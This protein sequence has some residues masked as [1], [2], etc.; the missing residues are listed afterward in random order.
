MN[1]V[2]Q[3]VVIGEPRRDIRG[4][5]LVPVVEMWLESK[6]LNALKFPGNYGLELFQVEFSRGEEMSGDASNHKAIESIIFCN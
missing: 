6:N 4:E 5:S 2:Q 1:R 3:R